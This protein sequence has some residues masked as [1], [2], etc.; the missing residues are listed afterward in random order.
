MNQTRRRPGATALRVSRRLGTSSVSRPTLWLAPLPRVG[1]VPGLG[2]AACAR[3][4]TRLRGHERAGERRGLLPV[5][6]EERL[7]P[8]QCPV[9]PGQADPVDREIVDQPRV[10]RVRGVAPFAHAGC[11][12]LGVAEL[13]G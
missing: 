3:R 5:L 6:V 2:G 9:A 13:G 4:A 8:C 12:L 10:E 1:A 7:E 11:G